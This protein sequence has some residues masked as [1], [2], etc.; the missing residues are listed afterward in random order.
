LN[1]NPDD[2]VVNEFP[3][4]HNLRFLGLSIAAPI[5]LKGHLVRKPR[6]GLGERRKC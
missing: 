1:Y 3:W 5:F 4:E 2:L 6:E